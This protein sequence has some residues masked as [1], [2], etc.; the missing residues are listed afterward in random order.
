MALSKDHV[1]LAIIDLANISCGV[2]VIWDLIALG[3]RII[4]LGSRIQAMHVL[5]SDHWR[6]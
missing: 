6:R 1:S 3:E 2:T 5:G 4:N